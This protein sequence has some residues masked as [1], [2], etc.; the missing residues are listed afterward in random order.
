MNIAG[1]I[2]SLANQG[3]SVSNKGIKVAKVQSVTANTCDVEL[4]DSGFDITGVRLQ[5][6][7]QDGFLCVPAIDSMV[8]IA[9]IDDFEYVVVMFSQLDS[10]K[11]LDGS[12]GG[13]IKI[14]DLITKLNNLENKVNSI[15]TTFNAHVH[16]GVTTGG[17]SSAISPTPITGTLTPTQIADIENDLITHGTV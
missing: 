11:M 13:L 9:P 12:Y 8:I 7:T 15:I 14:S 4:L 1:A 2:Q 10:I 16:T 3:Q 6:E 17:G 5:A